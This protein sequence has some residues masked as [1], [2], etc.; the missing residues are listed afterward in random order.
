MAVLLF[1]LIVPPSVEPQVVI[2]STTEELDDLIQSYRGIL[3]GPGS[4]GTTQLILRSRYPEVSPS[5]IYKILSSYFDAVAEG[6]RRRQ[7][8]DKAFEEKALNAL[9]NQVCG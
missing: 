3:R 6:R 8:A 1:N 9:N 2:A 5:E 7:L 4:N